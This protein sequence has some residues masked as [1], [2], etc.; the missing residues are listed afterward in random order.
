MEKKRKQNMVCV[1]VD[2][3]NKTI[4]IDSELNLNK[5]EAYLEIINTLQDNIGPE[6][7]ID[8][9]WCFKDRTF[10]NLIEMSEY[11]MEQNSEYV[12]DFP[13]LIKE[14]T[15]LLAMLTAIKATLNGLVKAITRGIKCYKEHNNGQKSVSRDDE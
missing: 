1:K 10:K 14:D 13:D 11:F 6:K 12:L 15:D 7:L 9:K 4:H 2:I 8:Y 5:Q 3:E